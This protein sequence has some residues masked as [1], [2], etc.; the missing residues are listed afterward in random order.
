MGEF[1]S[2]EWTHHTFNPW[3]GCTKVSPACKHCYA[4]AWAKRF[5]MDLWGGRSS[6]REFGEAH[7]R[8]PLRWNH[9]AA[10]SNAR[11]R[12]FCAS[13]GDVFEPR[14]D[15]EASRLRLWKLIEQTPA[16]DWLLL[17]KR[18]E[19]IADA[20]PWSSVWPANVWLGTTAETQLWADRRIPILFDH[21]AVVRFVSCE[22]LL[23]PLDLRRWLVKRDGQSGLDWIIVGGESGARARPMHPEWAASIQRQCHDAG[24]AFH[25]KQWGN[26]APVD[27]QGASTNNRR[28]TIAGAAGTV[29]LQRLTKHSAGRRLKGKE[30]DG[31]PTPRLPLRG[32][33]E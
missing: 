9:E 12:V 10:A 29:E 19:R 7:W 32:A 25:F 28:I 5:R 27:G 21:A 8:E 24:F 31:L 15:L 26:W 22:P 11:R 23:G 2:I 33:A 18:P 13:M 17:T 20:V 14:R 3:W 16:L 1:S 30:W 6:R 4:E